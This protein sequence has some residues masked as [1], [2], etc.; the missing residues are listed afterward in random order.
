MFKEF[1]LKT[2][3]SIENIDCWGMIKLRGEQEA[4][5]KHNFRGLSFLGLTTFSSCLFE[6]LNKP[7]FA[8]G[9]VNADF[10][11]SA[12]IYLNSDSGAFF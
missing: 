6:Q 9:Y 2:G 7:F 3:S 10:A 1:S 8:L 5:R 11:I 4:R 12:L